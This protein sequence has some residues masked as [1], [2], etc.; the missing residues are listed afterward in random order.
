GIRDFHVTGVQTCALP[1]LT[2]G[3]FSG[4]YTNQN[5]SNNDILMDQAVPVERLGNNFVV[6]KGNAPISSGMET[7]LVVA[8]QDNT[9][10]TVNGNPTGITLNEG[11]NTVM[12]GNNYVYQG[13]NNY[14]MS[15]STSKNVYVYQLLG[16]K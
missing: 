1:I 12:E 9:Q 8:T 13:N 11:D 10:I 2:N 7:L 6:V 14:N 3:N 16:G 5:F 4:I 15:V